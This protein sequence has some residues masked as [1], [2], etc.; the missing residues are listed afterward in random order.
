[1]VKNRLSQLFLLFTMLATIP[2]IIACT[3]VPSIPSNSQ[4]PASSQNKNPEKD[5]QQKAKG[6]KQGQA[7]QKAN[8]SQQAPKGAKQGQPS[9]KREQ[10]PATPI[11]I[12]GVNLV[13]GRPTDHS[14]TVNVLSDKDREIFFEYGTAQGSY[15]G[16]TAAASLSSMAPAEIVIDAL[17]PNTQYYYRMGYKTPAEIQ[18]T[19]GE[20]H[21]FQTQRTP[22]SS[23]AFT[24]EADYHRDQNSDPEEIAATFQNIL[25]EQ[26]DFNIDLGDT[27][28]GDKSVTSYLDAAKRYAADRSYF[29][30]F[31]SSVPLYLVNGNHEGES[32]WLLNGTENNLA[33]WATK[34][35]KSYYPNPYPDGFYTG[36]SKEEPFTGQ[37]QSYYSWEWGDALFV[38]LDPY[39]YT[40]TNPKQ[41]AEA[42]NCKWTLGFDQYTWLK[43]AL[44]TSKA[45]YKFVFTHH[46]LGDMRGGVEWAD[47]YE[48]G[49]QNRSGA[50]EFDKMRPGWGEPVHQLMV[51]NGVTI[52]FQGHDHL[53]NKR[54][55]SGS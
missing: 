14:I 21:S 30:I 18:F 55:I 42:D 39:W 20:E 16:K 31:G 6:G 8:G 3:P 13:L 48:W 4:T 29:G 50:W 34:A 28:M 27:F 37:R 36:S 22:G 33:V 25:Q 49:G 24:V 54:T 45:K 46:I 17:Q 12:T 7:S 23:F 47:L 41:G 53:R 40:A 38:V 2:I 15:N 5:T 9:Q 35:R 43:N 32:G 26:P 52:V 11:T 51:K 1:M 44:E 10:P 19:T